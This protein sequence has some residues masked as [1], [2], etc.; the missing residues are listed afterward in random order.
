MGRWLSLFLLSAP[1][2]GGDLDERVSQ[3][4]DWRTLGDYPFSVA[5]AKEALKEYPEEGQIHTLYI[6]SLAK[7]HQIKEM[8]HAFHA[9]EGLDEKLAYDSSL[10]EEMAWGVIEHASGSSTPMV[11]LI[12]MIASAISQD[13]IGVKLIKE[14]LR[15][16]N[17]LIRAVALELAGKLGDET[18]K[19]EVVR[20]FKEE[21]VYKTRI[22]AIVAC[23]RLHIKEVQGEIAHIVDDKNSSEEEK[24]AAIEALVEMENDVTPFHVELLLK[25]NRQ[26][27]KMVGCQLALLSDIPPSL[28]R[29][30]PLLDDPSSQVR[31]SALRVMGLLYYKDLSKKEEL[32]QISDRKMKDQNSL[33]Q[34][35]ALWLKTLLN[36]QECAPLWPP[37]LFHPD[38]ETRLF[39]S[40]LL[41]T[42]GE[43]GLPLLSRALSSAKDPFVKWNLALGLISL[44]QE[45]ERASTSLAT[46]L[47]ASHPRLMW[48]EKMGLRY[49]APST[50][51][52][53][54]QE[55]PS[56]VHQLCQLEILG[57]LSLFDSKRALEAFRTFLKQRSWE[58]LGPATSLLL[59]EGPSEAATLIEEL[60]K[61]ESFPFKVEAAL[62]LLSWTGDPLGADL[63]VDCYP[64]ADRKKRE[65]ILEALGSVGD[66]KHLPFLV[67]RL[68]EPYPI[69]RV[70]AASSILQLL[71]K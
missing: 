5:A 60:L 38:T 54:G 68:E 58:L 36:P 43:R 55:S 33:V 56:D 14:Q 23:G 49:L 50:L 17:S 4:R 66:K 59:T 67:E 47:E 24:E 34:A 32:L 35:A 51:S 9:F 53:A 2:W 21:R 26:H 39:A 40:A 18:F 62:L 63:L 69:L 27:Q 65:A 37:F 12:S 20:L 15:S 8:L 61:E 46:A 22:T 41:G 7:T 13:I 16:P 29:F 42:T 1:L 44:R 48:K 52:F 31:L 71:N 30:V 64:N 11:R 57:V 70:I 25:G 28:D 3:I 6:G 10:L 45:V 19:E